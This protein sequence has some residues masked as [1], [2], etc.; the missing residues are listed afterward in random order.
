MTTTWPRARPDLPE[1]YQDVYVEHMARNR[2]GGSTLNRLALGLEGWMHRQ[3]AQVPGRR[4]L[5][6]GGGG[7]NHLSYEPRA[8]RYDVVEPLAELVVDRPEVDGD[9]VR[10]L[11]G[12]DDL[13]ALAAGR[14]APTY[15][16]V[17]SVAVLEHLEDLPRVVADAA[18]LL[19]P[20]GWFVAGIPSEGGA[21]WTA[22]WRATTGAAFRRRY[23]LDYGVL[24][25]W[26]H[27]NTADEI[28]GELRRKFD[29][30]GVRRFPGPTTST[31]LY[32][33]VLCRGHRGR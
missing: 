6:L 11:G 2:G 4:V 5:E 8:A 3:V 13:A 30:V 29:E 17:L 21:L 12:Y 19:R 28:V 26:E 25:R 14:P 24:M 32:Q 10:Y 31:S 33:A 16:K 15:D 7:L 23:G 27:L 22:S 18:A 20:D 1:V 9:R